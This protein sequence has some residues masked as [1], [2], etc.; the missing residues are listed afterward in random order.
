[1]NFN[2]YLDIC[3]YFVFYFRLFLYNTIFL[4]ASSDSTYSPNSPTPFRND[5]NPKHI[6]ILMDCWD[7]VKFYEAEG[8][9]FEQR[10]VAE[11]D[12]EKALKYINETT[13]EKNTV[14]N[15]YI[16]LKISW[17]NTFLDLQ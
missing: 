4:M 3:I 2:S 15:H 7:P 5:H 9:T 17:Y 13:P 14:T 6:K 16:L 12:I 1:M 8:Y 11:K 10:R